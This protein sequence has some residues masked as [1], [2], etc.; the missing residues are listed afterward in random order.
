M[1]RVTP[2][3]ARRIHFA[4][5][6]VGHHGYDADRVDEFLE[7]VASTLEGGSG[8]TA[9]DIRRVDF[10]SPRFGARGYQADEVD[11][12]LDRV[13]AEL[14]HRARGVR[15]AP[16]RESRATGG[17]ILTPRDVHRV[18]FSSATV[19]RR[20]YHEEE[21][22]AFLDLVAASL[23]ADGPGT[24]T[25]A[26]VRAVHFT[27]ARVGTRGYQRDEVEAFLEL[28]VTALEFAGRRR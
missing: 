27:D 17:A 14:E 12:F 18:R 13:R 11:E 9:D 15:P 8:L 7:R 20:G 2:E 6:S 24:L 3:D 25:V 4:M 10:E 22:E 28:V 26:D 23:A 21:V 19:G 5:P 1:W 16:V